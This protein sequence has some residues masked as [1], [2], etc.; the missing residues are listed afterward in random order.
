MHTGPMSMPKIILGLLE[1]APR[2]GYDLKRLYDTRLAGDRP[3]SAAQI[4]AA[5]ARLERD[6]QVTVES[7]V[8]GDGPNRTI[9]AITK[10]GVADLSGWLL[11]PEKPQAGKQSVLFAKVVIALLTGRDANAFLDAQRA[12]HISRMRELTRVKR[13]GDVA[14]VL[15]ADH[16]LFHVEAD[17]RWLETTAERLAE[18]KEALR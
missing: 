3:V 11:E 9:Y 16:A 14:Q 12:A 6:G 2:H 4:Y 17:L 13:S 8:P 18:L 1:P 5:L 7:V 10:D 15:L